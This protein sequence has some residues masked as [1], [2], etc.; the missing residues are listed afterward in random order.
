MKKLVGSLKYRNLRYTQN[1]PLRIPRV[2]LLIEFL[3][4]MGLI[5]EQE[6]IQSREATEEELLLY[7][8]EDYLRALEESDRCMC[9]KDRYREKYNIGTYENPVSPAMWR[10]SLLAT[11]S[12]VQAVE[13]FLEGGVAFNPAGGMHHA[14]PSRANGFC[15][16]N[17]PAV[18]IEFL[19]KKGFKKILY[20][21]LDAHHCDAIQ[22]SYYQDDSVFV[23]SLHQSPEYAFP[24]K[25]GFA[26][27][28]G[29]G[30]G[31]GYNMNVPLPKGIKDGEYLYA[32]EESLK[33][34]KEIFSPDVYILQLGTDSLKE[35][36]LSKFELSNAG[37]LKAFDMVRDM[38]G[39]GI[40]LGGGGYHPIALA[41][42][43]ALIWCRISGREIPSKINSEAR[44]VLL[45]VNFE[46]FDEDIDRTYMYDY[47]LDR[48]DGEPPRGEVKRL[49]E[50]LK[51]LF[52]L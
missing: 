52:L 20:I 2:S 5:E 3:K 23:L 43:W 9:V 32:L 37:F 21:D 6:I 31:K 18:S 40:Y 33:I 47:L 44:Q 26:H 15:F 16:I 48:S 17:D 36:Y 8:T 29:R 46:E 1:H 12:S 51:A 19:K 13:V 7:H 45:S 24:F 14:Y 11:G 34:V 10:G 42:A 4:A 41:R 35:D 30:R 50:R 22:E 28:I 38:L 49:I 39:E 27:E 25:S